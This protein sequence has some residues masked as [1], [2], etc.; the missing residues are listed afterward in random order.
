ME[1]Y[2]KENY[3]SKLKLKYLKLKLIDNLKL[4]KHKNEASQKTLQFAI[5]LLNDILEGR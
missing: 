5:N 2:I 3:V 1:E 4:E